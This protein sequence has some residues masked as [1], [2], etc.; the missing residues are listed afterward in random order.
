M[1]TNLNL[2]WLISV[3]D[4]V[5][6]PPNVWTDRVPAKDRDRAPHLE[7][8][9]DGM[10]F[11]VYDG[12]RMPSSGLSAVVGKSKEEFSPE[13]VPYSE[14]APGCYDAAARVKD[15]DRAG[16]LASLCFPSVTRFCGQLFYEASDRD[17]GLVCLKAYNDWMIEE[18][19]G[20]APG[21]YI[22][23]ILIPLWDPRLAVKEMERCANK[24]ATTFAFSENPEP[25]G[26]P[27][28]HDK[29]GYWE[30]VMAAANDLEMVVSMHVGSSSTLPQICKDAPFMA[31]LTWG[32]TRTSGTMLSFLFSG[33]FQRYPNLKI[34]LSEGE[35]GW[36]PY[37][38]ERAEQVL[39]KQR[40]WV[41]K[42]VQF[43]EHAGSGAIDLD[44]LDVRASFRDHIFGC[45]IDD[46]H[47]IASIELGDIPEDNIMCETDYPHSDTTWPDSI[48]VIKNRIG[49]LP[50][51]TQYKILRG[52]AE[53][54]YRFTPAEP[55]VLAGV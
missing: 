8:D 9:D 3:D 34:A 40:H 23:L 18:W 43:M 44:T 54:L 19:C 35:A 25:L 24:G 22:P 48:G 27:T 42:G 50:E 52:N 26:L 47:A 32:A 17:F 33:L 55:P 31:N 46:A 28:I 36:I 29:D 53:R 12:K 2:D 41:K 39:D 6:E 45:I 11:W 38:L 51:E 4:H 7:V 13:P 20:A 16:I 14:M 49:H 30:P 37:F 1:A 15:M 10:D 5:L 21:R